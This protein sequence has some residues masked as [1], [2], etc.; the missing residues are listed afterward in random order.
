MQNVLY[1]GM[2]MVVRKINHYY[3]NSDLNAKLSLNLC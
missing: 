3:L 1:L 2:C